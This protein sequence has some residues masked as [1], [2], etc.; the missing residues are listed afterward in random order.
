MIHP[1]YI[2]FIILI[3]IV[4]ILFI[5]YLTIEKKDNTTSSNNQTSPKNQ[6]SNKQIIIKK[7]SSKCRG[8]FSNLDDYICCDLTNRKSCLKN[9]NCSWLT[10][11]DKETITNKIKDIGKNFRSVKGAIGKICILLS[12]LPSTWTVESNMQYMNVAGPSPNC[13]YFICCI[14]PNMSVKFSPPKGKNLILPDIGDTGPIYYTGLQFYRSDGN[15]YIKN[16]AQDYWTPDN[17]IPPNRDLIINGEP[18]EVIIACFRIYTTMDLLDQQETYL[19]TVEKYENDRWNNWPAAD[20]DFRRE[21]SLLCYKFMAPIFGLLANPPPE[22]AKEAIYIPGIESYTGWFPNVRSVYSVYTPPKRN[23]FGK[24]H[25]AKITGRLPKRQ[26]GIVYA[27]ISLINL[28]NSSTIQGFGPDELGN[29]GNEDFEIEI[30][31]IQETSPYYTPFSEYI[32]NFRLIDTISENKRQYLIEWLT[33][34]IGNT[35]TGWIKIK[36][37]EDVIIIDN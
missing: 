17:P 31:I 34:E 3:L 22:I 35:R 36:G 9:Q 23:R 33:G 14:G 1:L 6:K 25:V 5:I 18:N 30:P 21:I 10:N 12:S 15:P 27:D 32:I 28:R 20:T 11:I 24:K 19:P 16:N 26:D 2:L 8:R 4:L 13:T 29:F 37:V 7:C